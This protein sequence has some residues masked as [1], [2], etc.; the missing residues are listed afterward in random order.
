MEAIATADAAGLDGKRLGFEGD[1]LGI[2]AP[3]AIQGAAFQED[4]GADARPVLDGVS[5]HVENN[6]FRHSQHCQR[7]GINRFRQRGS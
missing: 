1:A 2:M 4:G 6:T 3:G 5:L 7:K